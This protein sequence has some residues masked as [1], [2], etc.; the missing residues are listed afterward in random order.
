[1]VVLDVA[2]EKVISEDEN[3]SFCLLTKHIDCI[4]ILVPGLLIYE[5]GGEEKIIG[6]DEGVL[7]KCKDEVRVS[8]KNAIAGTELGKMKK[9]LE[10]NI[11]K[12]DD[13]EKKTRTILT[14]IE[15]DFIKKY[16]ETAK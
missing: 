2:T 15:V 3:G 7:I 13:Y 4:R 6:I 10:D 12:I 5:S 14:E 8:V 16:I 11:E 9:K 1:M